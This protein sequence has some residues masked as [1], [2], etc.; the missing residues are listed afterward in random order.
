MDKRLV[1][2]SCHLTEMLR[3]IVRGV[4]LTSDQNMEG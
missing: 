2:I 3:E 1:L 4:T